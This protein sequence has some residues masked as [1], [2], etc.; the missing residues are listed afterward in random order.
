VVRPTS[1]PLDRLLLQCLSEEPRIQRLAF[2]VIAALAMHW[3][4]IHHV[5]V[6]LQGSV[7]ESDTILLEFVI[8]HMVL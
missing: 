6:F 1:D 3:R 4:T 8:G 2:R 7:H 5:H